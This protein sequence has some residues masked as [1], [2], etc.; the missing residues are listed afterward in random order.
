MRLFN[1]VLNCPHCGETAAHRVMAYGDGT[2]VSWCSVCHNPN[3][4][5]VAQ[6]RQRNPDKTDQAA[7]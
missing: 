4:L 6:L 3:E 7:E 2:A 1:A 5:L